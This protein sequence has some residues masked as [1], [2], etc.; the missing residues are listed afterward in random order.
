MRRFYVVTKDLHLYFGL[1]ISPFVLLFA[2]SVFFLVHAWIPGIS[3]E[4]TV[5]AVEHIGLPDIAYTSNGGDQVEAL[6]PVLGKLGVSGEVNFVRRIPKEHRLIVPIL[7]P[8]RETTVELNFETHA[9]VIT[10]HRTSTWDALVHLHKMP[11]PH[12]A[13]IRGNSLY[14]RLWRWLAD[15]TVYLIVFISISGI[16]LWAVLRA[17]RRIGFILITAGAFSFFGI[18]YVLA[19]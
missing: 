4:T 14:I 12:N 3:R 15:S 17:E 5:R 18:V 8:G 16:Y 6:R 1:F 11:G 13:N 7:I 19:S 10:E 2:V 9:A